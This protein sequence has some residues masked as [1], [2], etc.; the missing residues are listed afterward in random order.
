[1]S[2]EIVQVNFRM[3]AAL[4]ARL[5]AASVENHRTLTA[6]IIA[7]LESTL[8]KSTAD[9]TD[10]FSVEAIEAEF[11]RLLGRTL[12]RVRKAEAMA[13]ASRARKPRRDKAEGAN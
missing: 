5:E 3:P 7:R 12:D 2:D 8:P 4:K 6:E 13:P 10:P 11:A 9:E 1:M